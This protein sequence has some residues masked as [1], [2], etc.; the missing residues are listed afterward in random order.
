MVRRGT[1]ARR[2]TRDPLRWCR[3]RLATGAVAA[4]VVLGGISIAL[5]LVAGGA[6]G[7]GLGYGL[8][9]LGVSVILF[10][11]GWRAGLRRQVAA[12]PAVR[13][14]AFLLQAAQLYGALAVCTG[15]RLLFG[16]Q[17]AG[18]AAVGLGVAVAGGALTAWAFRA[19]RRKKGARQDPP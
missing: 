3:A 13:R 18:R 6:G 4:A 11:L 14:P 12:D 15:V 8:G 2:R 5:L 17:T 7:A 1:P 10:G 16:G 19:G 9:G